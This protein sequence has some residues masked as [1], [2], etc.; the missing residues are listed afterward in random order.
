MSDGFEDEDFGLVEEAVDTMGEDLQRSESATYA[1]AEVEV[2]PMEAIE[3][4]CLETGGSVPDAV[5]DNVQE[6]GGGYEGVGIIPE[7]CCG[8]FGS[9]NVDGYDGGSTTATAGVDSEEQEEGKGAE[10]K[11]PDASGGGE[12]G[13]GGVPP[14]EERRISPPRRRDQ[15]LLKGRLSQMLYTRNPEP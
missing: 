5:D 10:R 15:T 13:T 12:A 3:E 14:G 6:D 2:Y 11:P 4:E 8:S 9:A 7:E 1:D